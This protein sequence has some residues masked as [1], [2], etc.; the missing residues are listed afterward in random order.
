MSYEFPPER[1]QNSEAPDPGK[2]TK[3]IQPAARRLSELREHNADASDFKANASVD[4]SAYWKHYAG[5]KT[6]GPGL[7]TNL[8]P[9]QGGSSSPDSYVNIPHDHA[10][11][12]VVKTDSDVV[13]V[14][15][16]K[17][18]IN[19]WAVFSCEGNTG[20]HTLSPSPPSFF[21]KA[22]LQFALRING[23]VIEES[24]VG[25]SNLGEAPQQPWKHPD[26]DLVKQGSVFNKVDT[27]LVE[28]TIKVTR[29]LN[30]ISLQRPGPVR[31][32]WIIE[33]PDGTHTVELVARRV[34]DQVADR[35]GAPSKVGWVSVYNRQIS[36]LRLNQGG[37][38]L[39]PDN[40]SVDPFEDGDTL[41]A[42]ELHTQR[43]EALRTQINDLGEGAL[44]GP[45]LLRPHL[46][47][48]IIETEQKLATSFST[49]TYTNTWPGY[50]TDDF[51]T[52]GPSA[53]WVVLN[54]LI[55]NGN[56]N[57]FNGNLE[58]TIHIM[59]N[60]EV[61]IIKDILAPVT[62]EGRLWALF[63]LYE[64]RGSTYTVIKQSECFI[65]S[66]MAN[67]FTT[68]GLLSGIT[69]GEAT[70]HLEIPELRRDVPLM[71]VLE[72]P[73]GGGPTYD[74]IGVAIAAY[75][76]SSL[77]VNVQVTVA[78]GSIQVFQLKS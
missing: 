53:G 58:S 34:P 68:L 33:V 50:D 35:F 14:A 4:R 71:A 27:G 26:P 61:S 55:C 44:A 24:L 59:A 15:G 31:L 23:V 7:N 11:H 42:A 57:G 22:F 51:D 21:W 10:W 18:W 69:G 60:V 48:G 45:S 36:V 66:F 52:S 41:T 1:L 54:E 75:H 40:V 46:P 12:Q 64:K 76:D 49:S 73:T 19:A 63:C 28:E 13:C 39:S 77:P 78:R 47:S 16:D 43:L 74:E 17:L 32:G 2:L 3:A 65:P 5:V 38:A 6:V 30:T 67:A 62:P 29:Y 25:K 9:T 70:T 56:G 72:H 20:A 37:A 8:I